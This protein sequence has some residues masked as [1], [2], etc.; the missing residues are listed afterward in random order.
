MLNFWM[1]ELLT[2]IFEDPM[3]SI[4]GELKALRSLKKRV[5]VTQLCFLFELP[6]L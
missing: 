1:I 2:S 3:G 4:V 6:L 5:G